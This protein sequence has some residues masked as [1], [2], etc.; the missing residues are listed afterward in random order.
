M[1]VT[2]HNEGIT[3]S[4]ERAEKGMP[5]LRKKRGLDT[6]SK[7]LFLGEGIVR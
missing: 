6:I 7:V 1:Y 4:G 2:S 5:D 3:K